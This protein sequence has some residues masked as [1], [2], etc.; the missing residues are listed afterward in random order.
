MVRADYLTPESIVGAIQD[1]AFYAT[2]GVTLRDV[3]RDER[4]LTVEVEPEPDVRYTTHFI[5]RGERR[6]P[7]KRTGAQPG[8]RAYDNAPALHKG[9]N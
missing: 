9:G 2:T 3:R 4:A 8:R 1:G 7:G 6:R 5:G